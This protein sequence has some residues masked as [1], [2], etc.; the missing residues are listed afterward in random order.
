M[1]ESGIDAISDKTE[2]DEYVFSHMI[3]NNKGGMQVSGDKMVFSQEMYIK[4][5]RL[6]QQNTKYF[7][8]LIQNS[9]ILIKP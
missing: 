4:K 1:Q 9:L 5:F 2:T 8:K 7:L 3:C 6:V